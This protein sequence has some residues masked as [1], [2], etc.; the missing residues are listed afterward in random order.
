MTLMTSFDLSCLFKMAASSQKAAEAVQLYFETS[1]PVTVIRT[2]HKQ[3]PKDKKLSKQQI[4][5]L[6]KRFQQTGSV[7]DSR[8]YN[9]GRPRTSRS[10][11]NIADVE[12]IIEE[13]PQKSVRQVLGDVTNT[14]RSS[15]GS[16]YRTLRFELKLYPYTLSVMQHLKDSDV[17]YRL[18]FARW[19]ASHPGIL[20]NVWFSDESHFHLNG[21]VDSQNCRV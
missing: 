7:Q 16:F 5:R 4:L 20:D 11:E 9:T 2:M 14:S 8:H 19:A 10:A 21:S 12:K 15:Y 18:E 6:V 13:T 3:Y 1:S 17:M